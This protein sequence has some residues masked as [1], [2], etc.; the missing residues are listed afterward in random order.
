MLSMHEA[1]DTPILPKKLYIYIHTS[2]M[3]I[4]VNRVFIIVLSICP[5]NFDLGF[6]VT[7]FPFLSDTSLVW[8]GKCFVNQSAELGVRK[9][10]L[11]KEYVLLGLQDSNG[12]QMSP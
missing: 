8:Y 9:F 4:L 12:S 10:K 11:H 5:K 2:L 7:L 3:E 1:S 6:I